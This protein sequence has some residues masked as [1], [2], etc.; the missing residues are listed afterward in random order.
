MNFS[1][2][3]SEE[4]INDSTWGG[5]YHY[6]GLTGTV[7]TT[8]SSANSAGARIMKFSGII[9]GDGHFYDVASGT[10]TVGTCDTVDESANVEF[11]DHDGSIKVGMAV[12]GTGIPKYAVVT[13]VTDNGS[14]PDRFAMNVDATSTG[15]NSTLTFAVRS[16]TLGTYDYLYNTGDLK[17]P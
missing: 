15:S 13:S 7:T 3:L 10:F 9:N 4:Y 5:V 2:V 6:K 11:D 16:G 14:N 12:F 8:I 17:A 1:H